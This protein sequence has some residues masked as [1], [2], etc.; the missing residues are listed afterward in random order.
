MGGLT[1]ERVLACAAQAYTSVLAVA[2]VLGILCVLRGF[3]RKAS[4]KS[5]P[6]NG[7]HPEA[8]DAVTEIAK[9]A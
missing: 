2:W 8:N 1:L 4:D 7:L 5:S 9:Q 6:M 3:L